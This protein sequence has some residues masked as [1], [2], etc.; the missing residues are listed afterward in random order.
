MVLIICSPLKIM[1]WLK[2]HVLQLFPE[3]F[4][5]GYVY[6]AMVLSSKHSLLSPDDWCREAI[7]AAS[8]C[9]TVNVEFHLGPAAS[10]NT[11]VQCDFLCCVFCFGFGFI[12]W[13]LTCMYD[14]MY[15]ITTC[16]GIPS[17]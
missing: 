9:D 10:S 3:T 7:V 6:D 4:V 12:S 15:I 8:H 5:R 2:D 17:W 1:R 16:F 14:L 11:V 13:K